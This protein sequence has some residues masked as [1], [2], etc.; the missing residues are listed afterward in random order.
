M[1]NMGQSLNY[2]PMVGPQD[3]RGNHNSMGMN[4]GGAFANGNEGFGN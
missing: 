2:G 4:G 1:M 3:N